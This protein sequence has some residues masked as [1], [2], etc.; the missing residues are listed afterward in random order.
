MA[1]ERH[2]VISD[3]AALAALAHPVRLDVL[4]HL[5]SNGPA[6]ASACA[7]A[8][9]DSPSNCSY[10]LRTLARHGLVAPDESADGRERPWRAQVTGFSVAKAEPGT[11]EARSEAMLLA[12]AVQL[13]QRRLVDY[14]AHRDDVSPQWRTA[15]S[16]STYGLRVTPDELV[17]LHEQ[18]DALIRPFISATREDPPEGSELVQ[19]GLYAFPSRPR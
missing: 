4:N 15:D 16:Y 11:D 3:A 2:P 10:H 14:Y 7:R 1:T 17:S 5:M 19:V 18:L 6:T 13:D 9:G 12:A 8:V